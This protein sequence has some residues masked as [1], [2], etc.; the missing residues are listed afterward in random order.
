MTTQSSWQIQQTEGGSDSG[1]VCAHHLAAAKAGAAMLKRGGNAVD[2]AVATGFAIGVVEPYNSGL[3]GI[4]QLLYR[5]SET[6]RVTVF[7]GTSL[8]P[9][10]IDPSMFPLADPPG[11]AGMYAWP[12]VEG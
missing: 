1:I 9:R 11:V 3:G 12:A 7:D 8:L 6:G 5:D 10:R 2:A 4:A